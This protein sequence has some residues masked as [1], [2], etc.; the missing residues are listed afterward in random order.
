MG[1]QILEGLKKSKYNEAMQDLEDHCLLRYRKVDEVVPL[2]AEAAVEIVNF[3][4]R[5]H[6][7]EPNMEL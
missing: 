5:K 1:L 3:K 6:R 4:Q 2:V 7:K